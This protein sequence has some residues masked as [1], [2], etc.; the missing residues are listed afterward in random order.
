LEAGPI[1]ILENPYL[2]NF[3]KGRLPNSVPDAL[4]VGASYLVFFK[5]YSM[6]WL[7]CSMVSRLF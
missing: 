7:I 3:L 5:A 2:N 6:W 1:Q 4:I